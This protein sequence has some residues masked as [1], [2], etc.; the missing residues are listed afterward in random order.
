MLVVY[1]I[2]PLL[3]F[4]RFLLLFS[5]IFYGFLLT[6]YCRFNVF[7]LSL[8]FGIYCLFVGFWQVNHQ[9]PEKTTQ[10][11]NKDADNQPNEQPKSMA[12]RSQQT[13]KTQRA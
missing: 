6:L 4:Y 13:E 2:V 1:S 3:V 10:T 9:D 5:V 12:G 11:T 8:F 7:S